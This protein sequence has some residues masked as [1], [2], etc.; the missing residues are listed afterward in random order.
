M[1]VRR[2]LGGLLQPPSSR[3]PI[4]RR[5]LAKGTWKKTRWRVW[6]IAF[7][8]DTACGPARG[9]TTSGRRPPPSNGA[10]GYRAG[11]NTVEVLPVSPVIGVHVGPAVGIAYECERPVPGKLTAPT[12]ELVFSL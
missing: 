11:G 12:G 1:E 7:K 2:L 10:R 3:W 4:G 8:E 5:L 6:S 9:G